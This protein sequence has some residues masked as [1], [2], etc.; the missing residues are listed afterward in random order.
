MITAWASDDPAAV[1]RWDHAA[2]PDEPPRR[3]FVEMIMGLPMSVHVRGPQADRPVVA[4]AVADVFTALR[5]DDELF[6]TWK[7]NSPVSRIRRGDLRLQ[8]A[9]DRV[10][11][12]AA[13]CEEAAARTG[14]SFSAW[15]PGPAGEPMFEPTGLVKG[16]A[17][18]QAFD[19]L[20]TNL[21]RIGPH[22]ALLSAGGDIALSCSRT[23]TPDWRI[24]IE[25]PRQ[26]DRCLLTVRLRRG[27]VATSGAAARGD[28]I[29]DPAT[30]VPPGGLLSA[31]V[32]GPSLTWADVYATAAFVRGSAAPAWVASLPDHAAVLLGTDG[33]LQ[34]VT[35]SARP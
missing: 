27:A 30:G 10:Q 25:D 16:W 26:R 18:E 5:S 2:T 6:S 15:L 13:L 19:R 7:P 32:I 9:G 35:S 8:D 22:D 33:E 21:A 29:I 4:R 28:H 11:Q 31:T 14:G 12:V 3:A 24:A 34:T 23:D 1:P 17:A 20:V